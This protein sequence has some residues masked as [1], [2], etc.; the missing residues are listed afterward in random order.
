MIDPLAPLAPGKSGRVHLLAYAEA[1]PQRT[2]GVAGC[3]AVCGVSDRSDVC[4]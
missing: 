3:L 1:F 2:R 4:F